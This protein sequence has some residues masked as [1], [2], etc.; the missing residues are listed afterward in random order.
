MSFGSKIVYIAKFAMKSCLLTFFVGI[1]WPLQVG[2]LFTLLVQPLIN[3]SNNNSGLFNGPFPVSLPVIFFGA[4]WSLGFPLLRVLYSL[5][6]HLPLPTATINYIS[7]LRRL[8]QFNV[9]E[10]F[11]YAAVPVTLMLTFALI[12]PPLSCLIAIPLFSPNP[13]M[14]TVIEFQNSAHSLALL[15]FIILKLVKAA[16]MIYQRLISGI[17]DETYL[18]GRR[19]HNLESR[20]TNTTNTTNETRNDMVSPLM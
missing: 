18:V 6:S 19:L 2:L 20:S 11:K 4:C 12:L 15:A 16:L 1:I 3:N 8:E 14:S 13:S 17:R 7:D 10:F 9:K 5:R